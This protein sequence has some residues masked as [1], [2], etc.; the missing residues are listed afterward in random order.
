VTSKFPYT[1]GIDGG[2][3]R[4]R[5]RLRNID[6]KILAEDEAGSANVH[7]N[8]LDSITTIRILIEK[9]IQKTGIS[10]IKHAEISLGLGLAGIL[11]SGDE[12]R[13]ANEFLDFGNVFVTSDAVT[14]CI[15]AHGDCDGGLVIAGTGTA[16]LARLKG[17]AISIGGRGFALGDDGSGAR[18][19]WDALRQA[20]LAADCLREHT[21]LT[22]KLMSRFGNDPMAVTRWSLNAKS[23]DYASFAPIVFGFADKGDDVALPIIKDAGKAIDTL[24]MAVSKLGVTRIALVGGISGAI[25]P[26]LSHNSKFDIVKPERDPIDGAIMLAGGNIALSADYNEV[27]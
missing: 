10:A 22:Y 27:Q 7:L 8:F 2:G 26:Y 18:I 11:A 17:K 16:G 12:D 6:G 5:G 3:T 14:A 15:G 20:L 13:V 1:I 21:Q 24:A 9:L 23:G 4:C 19:G 25:S